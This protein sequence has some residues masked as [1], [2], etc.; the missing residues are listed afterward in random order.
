[1]EKCSVC[2]GETETQTIAYS[3]WIEGKLVVVE[4]VL[5][6]VC[7]SCGE[8]YFSPDTVNK[9]QDAVAS[10]KSSKIMEVPVYSL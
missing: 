2:K 3:Q 5:A 8:E 4:N 9:I 10:R 6:D 1:M 7:R